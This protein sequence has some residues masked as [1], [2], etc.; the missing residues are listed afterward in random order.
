M[1]FSALHSGMD[2][3]IFWHSKLIILLKSTKKLCSIA[4]DGITVCLYSEKEEERDL[5]ELN[6]MHLDCEAERRGE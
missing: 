3:C 6:S 4:Y 5:S 2:G 1:F